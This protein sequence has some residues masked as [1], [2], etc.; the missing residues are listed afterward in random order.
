MVY[1]DHKILE[2]AFEKNKKYFG[3]FFEAFGLTEL[4]F[5]EKVYDPENGK[6]IHANFWVDVG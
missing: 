4:I 5:D 1:A 3:R 6:Q 2:H